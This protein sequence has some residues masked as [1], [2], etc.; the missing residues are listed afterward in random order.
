MAT[1]SQMCSGIPEHER[2]YVRE[3]AANALFMRRKLKELRADLAGQDPYIPY[4]NGGGQT[5]IRR[6]PAFDA[7]ESLLKSYTATL[8][9]LRE[10]LGGADCAPKGRIVSIVGNSKWAGRQA[11]NG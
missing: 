9:E 5:G 8:R 4:D 10:I 2:P 6:N 11:A 7:Y 3:L 1:M